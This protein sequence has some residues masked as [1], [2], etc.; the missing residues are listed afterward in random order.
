MMKGISM[1]NNKIT[2][3]NMV[4]RVTLAFI[5][6]YH[7]LVPK[8]IWLSSVEVSLTSAHNFGVSAELI[9]TVAG[10]MEILLGLSIVLLRKSLA[11]IYIAMILL[12][13]LLVDVA[14]VMPMLLVDAF[15]PVTINIASIV[16]GYIIVI[17]QQNLTT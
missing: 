8:I 13:A 5:F 14:I 2:H 3:I 16:V 9:S 10:V 11:P 4:S 6:I 7:G 1:E 12:V 15:N 17:T